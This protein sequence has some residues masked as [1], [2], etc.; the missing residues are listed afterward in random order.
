MYKNLRIINTINS[1]E[2]FIR[3]L[4]K[5]ASYDKYSPLI[6]IIPDLKISLFLSINGP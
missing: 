6:S 5:S 3:S 1:C 2:I 4:S